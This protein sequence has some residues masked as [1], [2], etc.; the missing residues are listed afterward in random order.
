MM[1]LSD[2]DWVTVTDLKNFS[3]CP[4]ITY[5]EQCLP[6]VRPKTYLMHAGEEEH[7]KE[8]ER[9]RRRTLRAY[10]LP[11]GERFFGVKLACE[12]L[13]LRGELDELVI[14]PDG[15]YLP[16]DYKLSMKLNDSFIHQI[17]AYALLIER[18]FQTVVEYG[19]IYLM[20]TR[21]FHRIEMIEIHRLEVMTTIAAIREMAVREQMPSPPSSKAKCRACEF[22]RFCNDV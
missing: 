19:Y 21:V 14:T 2:A 7:E 4:R 1:P 18:Q 10:D 3:H 20:T 15:R 22:R 12:D 9:A 8:R 5:F 13:G 16:A 6:G 11:D 17:T